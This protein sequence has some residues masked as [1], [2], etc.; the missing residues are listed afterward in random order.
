M[1]EKIKTN[2]KY[3]VTNK[4]II[5]RDIRAKYTGEGTCFDGVN[6]EP[7]GKGVAVLQNGDSFSGNFD[8]GKPVEGMYTFENGSYVKIRY[9]IGLTE[10]YSEPY[11]YG[12]PKVKDILEGDGDKYIGETKKGIAHGIGK[13]EY[14]NMP[15]YID[16][17][18]NPHVYEGGFKNGKRYG[19][20]KYTYGDG[21]YDICVYKPGKIFCLKKSE[22]QKKKDNSIENK[23]E[24]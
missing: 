24:C 23:N 14:Y 11:G 4:N 21:S 13:I 6:I 7:H 5:F 1:N 10:I 3:K 12:E 16:D 2:K 22:A 20:G 19:V 15:W 9:E 17:C 8:N 18:E